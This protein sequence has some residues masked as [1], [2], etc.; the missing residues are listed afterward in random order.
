LADV[1]L[2]IRRKLH[3]IHNGVPHI[4]GSLSAGTW[5]TIFVVAV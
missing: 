4:S 3:C 2:I 1:P 5:I